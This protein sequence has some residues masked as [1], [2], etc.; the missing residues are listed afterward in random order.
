MET[1]FE[2]IDLLTIPYC[3]TAVCVTLYLMPPRFT[4]RNP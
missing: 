2:L 3:V 1:V 4:K